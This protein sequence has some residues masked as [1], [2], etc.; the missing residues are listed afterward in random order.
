M[1]FDY[2]VNPYMPVSVATFASHW[3]RGAPQR[4]I[5]DTNDGVQSYEDATGN[6]DAVMF[7]GDREAV[8]ARYAHASLRH[9]HA[10]AADGGRS[11]TP[12]P[13][14]YVAPAPP[15]AR[16]TPSPMDWEPVAANIVTVEREPEPATYSNPRHPAPERSRHHHHHHHRRR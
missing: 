9:R 10:R 14:R 7:G 15:P 16:R 8:Q 11:L 13:E 5:W 6:Q 1:V 3:R 2:L 4:Q 12:S